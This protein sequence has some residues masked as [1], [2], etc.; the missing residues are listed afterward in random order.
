VDAVGQRLW[1]GL[2]S[3]TAQNKVSVAKGWGGWEVWRRKL[4]LF[5]WGPAYE[6]SMEMRRWETDDTRLAFS[7]VALNWVAWSGFEYWGV[8][9]LCWKHMHWLEGTSKWWLYAERDTAA[10]HYFLF[11]CLRQP[12]R[13]FWLSIVEI[14]LFP[15]CETQPSSPLA[16]FRATLP[17]LSLSMSAASTATPFKAWLLAPFDALVASMPPDVT[18]RNVSAGK[19]SMWLK[20]LPNLSRGQKWSVRVKPL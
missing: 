9:G 16:S 11:G 8:K 4:G 12:S 14:I 10:H 13:P 20:K 1:E 5:W 2:R 3:P 19:L 15:L 6:Q 7:V 17:S 18:K